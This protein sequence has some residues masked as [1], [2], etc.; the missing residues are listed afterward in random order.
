MTK[1]QTTQS[2]FLREASML[3]AAG[4]VSRLIGLLYRVPLA[5]IL[6]D[7]GN[8]Y[9]STAYNIYIIVLLISSYSIPS[10]ISKIM[11][12][13]IQ[14]REYK[15]VQ[16]IF[17]ASL[18]YVGVLGLAASFLLFFGA[19]LLIQG[20][21]AQVLQVFAPTVFFYGF[22]GVLRGYFQAHKSMAQTS[23]SQIF[24]Q[25]MN[26]IFSIG[27]AYLFMGMFQAPEYGAMGSAIGT[28]AGVVTAF[29]FMLW[30]YRV[31]QPYL[32]SRMRHDR[33]KDDISQV[34]MIQMVFF[35]VAPIILSTFIYNI[36]TTLNNQLF[37][38]ISMGIGKMTEEES[39]ALYGIFASKASILSNVPIAIASSMSAAIIPIVSA[40]YLS[41]GKREA[42]EQVKTAIHSTMIL[43]IP[44][45][46]GLF[47][48]AEPIISLI[49]STGDELLLSTQLLQLMCISI[50]SYSLSTLT[51][52]VLQG[53]GLVQKPVRN[54][55]IALVIQTIVVIL[56]LLVTDLGIYSLTIAALVYSMVVCLLNQKALKTELSLRLAWFRS[57]VLPLVSAVVMG[58]AVFAIYSLLQTLFQLLILSIVLSIGIGVFSYLFLLILLGGVNE[59]ELRALP[60]GYV[61]VKFMKKLVRFR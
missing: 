48:L 58:I 23:L 10:A 39:Y 57:M 17:R 56:L 29:L 51:N 40:A 14:E 11:A 33:S 4:M 38:Q 54:S 15:T 55:A 7:E 45:A 18:L 28:G 49:F 16:R 37:I 24:E 47:V 59:K 46:V 22:L 30:V 36:S 34:Q 27:M 52:G 43:I 35:V 32:K 26:C 6:T 53:I 60:K 9:Y 50:V 41:E 44:A 8:G 2:N 3:A 19:E 20:K 31:N 61:I 1:K 42:A 13:K 5:N 21:A 12:A 25:I